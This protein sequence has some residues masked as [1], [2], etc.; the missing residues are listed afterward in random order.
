MALAVVAMMILF[1][2]GVGMLALASN[3]RVFS[4]RMASAVAARCAA[5]AGVTKALFEMNQK[6]KVKPWNDGS[7]PE[8]TDESLPGCSALY[9]YSITGDPVSGYT[10]ESAGVSGQFQKT[11]SCTL[12]PQ[13]P[14]EFAVFANQSLN[15][16]NSAVVSGYN[17][18]ADDKILEVG[19]NSD[20][21]GAILLNN[22]ATIDG[23]VVVGVGAD[24]SA[25]ISD[26]GATIT[27]EA[28]AMTEKNPLPEIEVPHSLESLPSSGTLENG[29]TITGS[30]KYSGIDLK[31]KQTIIIDGNVSLYTTGDVILNNS[32]ELQIKSDAS[33]ILYLGG[34]F[35]GKNSSSVNNL[36]KDAKKLQIYCLDNCKSV[37]L[38]NG[39]DFYGVIYGPHADVVL[40][41]SGNFYGSVVAQNFEQRNSGT[42]NYDASLRDVSVDDEAVRFVVTDWREQ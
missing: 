12:K 18:G 10:V 32:A 2:M 20:D 23:D 41:N 36:T 25:V 13:G 29:A 39:V 42:F 38:K 17:F 28:R 33:L 40:D 6:L 14:F 24:P 22:S 1:A 5:D 37:R 34:N 8:A 4:A 7:L 15:L 35:E 9:S 26:H 27:G 11:V 16:D 30:A 3:T 19:T 21:S 31:T